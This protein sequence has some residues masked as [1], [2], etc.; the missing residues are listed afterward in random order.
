MRFQGLLIY[1]SQA[2]FNLF[3]RSFNASLKL[4][5]KTLDKFVVIVYNSHNEPMRSF[6]ADAGLTSTVTGFLGRD[7]ADISEQFLVVCLY[8]SSVGTTLAV[9]RFLLQRK[10]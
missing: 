3:L 2:Y 10:D 9:A 5:S 7:N 8:S 1:P 4:V 6:H